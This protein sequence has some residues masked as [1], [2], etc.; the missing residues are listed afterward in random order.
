MMMAG[1]IGADLYVVKRQSMNWMDVGL[2]AAN[3][4]P[5]PS[6]RDDPILQNCRKELY[7]CREVR[8]YE[9]TTTR[10]PQEE[11]GKDYD[12]QARVEFLAVYWDLR[13]SL[14]AAADRAQHQ[15]TVDK[16]GHMRV[17]FQQAH[18]TLVEEAR[19]LQGD[20]LPGDLIQNFEHI[21]LR[22]D[23][24]QLHDVAEALEFAWHPPENNRRVCVLP[25]SRTG[26]APAGNELPRRHRAARDSALQS[27]DVMRR[28]QR[29]LQPL[30]LQT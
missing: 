5:A 18:A 4:D 28:A 2:L 16:H 11:H 9:V 23:L 14:H 1:K 19:V 27:N 29:S 24:H 10:H 3:D 21:R 12:R 6:T 30:S 25:W 26:H 13:R 7:A 22:A 17:R 8:A 15:A 20:D